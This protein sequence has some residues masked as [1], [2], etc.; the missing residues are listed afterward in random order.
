MMRILS[1]LPSATEIA[2]ALGLGEELVG[3]SHECDYPPEARTKPIIS[4]SD[5]R[6]TLRSDEVH[7]AVG[8]HSHS[9]H[10]LYRIDEQL[11][12]EVSPDIILTQEL[13]S[14][15]AVPVSQV[16][17]AARILAGSCR[18]LSLEPETFRQ[19]LDSILAV[20]EVTGREARA[21]Q[22]VEALDKRIGRVSSTGSS[23][24]TRPR[25]FCMEWMDPVMAGGHW[26]PEMVRLAGGTDNLG[27]DGRPSTVIEWAQVA[28]YSPEFLVI[29]PCGYKVPRSLA[30]V[31]RLASRPGWYRMPAVR[32]GRV[33]IVDSPAYFSR[34]GPRIVNGLEILA[35][36]IHPELFSGLI[37]GDAVVKLAWKE[38]EPIEGQRM[39]ERFAPLL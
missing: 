9:A 24:R 16:R 22:V 21:R 12:Q 30:E 1:L 38:D 28:E 32:D 4:T 23:A 6:R 39:S 2:Y 34:P 17:E 11:L 18:I 31:D 15:C 33:Y 8:S 13:C 35:Q 7:R 14:V 25:I 27:H 26:I 36:I 19:I 20:G 10:S 3:I 29:M 5:V 37:P